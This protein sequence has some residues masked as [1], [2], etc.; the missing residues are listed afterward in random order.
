MFDY[1]GDGGFAGMLVGIAIVL[2]VVAFV[3]YCIHSFGGGTG[4]ACGCGRHP[5]WRRCG[6]KKLYP[7]I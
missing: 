7:V 4:G 1:D 5:V 3:I 6:S 2:A